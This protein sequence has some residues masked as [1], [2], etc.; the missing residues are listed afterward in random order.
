[1]SSQPGFCLRSPGL[2]C[3]WVSVFLMHRQSVAPG[4]CD[5]RIVSTAPGQCKRFRRADGVSGFVLR[6]QCDPV[7]VISPF[8]GDN[9]LLRWERYIFCFSHSTLPILHRFLPSLEFYSFSYRIILECLGILFLINIPGLNWGHHH[10]SRTTRRKR[11]FLLLLIVPICS[12]GLFPPYH[13]MSHN[14]FAQE[15]LRDSHLPLCLYPER[16]EVT[17]VWW[18]WEKNN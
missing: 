9:F 16:G 17:S 18:A 4:K 12:E 1:M 6:D 15:E 8:G 10:W 14:P 13:L 7:S 2:W 3:L 5:K 11:E